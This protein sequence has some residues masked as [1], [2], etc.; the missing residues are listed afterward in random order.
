MIASATDQGEADQKRRLDKKQFCRDFGAWGY[1]LLI[2]LL[3]FFIVFIFYT[4]PA[5]NFD[6]FEL[7]RDNALYYVCVT[8]SALS[9]YTY[10]MLNWVRGMHVFILILGMSV[11]ISL[12]GGNPTPLF[13][14]YDHRK[15][16]FTFLLVSILVGFLT[17]LYSSIKRGE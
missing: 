9:L 12:A 8:M 6:F 11:Y 14:I 10:K 17:L 15:I 3:P 2:S 5:T 4:G 16:L 13:D 7:F 1:A